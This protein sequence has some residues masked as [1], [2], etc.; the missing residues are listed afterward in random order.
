ME[1]NNIADAAVIV[2]ADNG[3]AIVAAD[4]RNADGN[5]NVVKNA[6]DAAAVDNFLAQNLPPANP[7]PLPQVQPPPQ[8]A[9]GQVQPPLAQLPPVQPSQVQPPPPQ[10]GV[11]GK[12]QGA[13]QQQQHHRAFAQGFGAVQQQPYGAFAQGY[14]AANHPVLGAGPF[15][16]PRAHQFLGAPAAGFPPPNAAQGFG[17][18]PAAHG[19][20]QGFGTGLAALGALDI[21]RLRDLAAVFQPQAPMV[22]PLAMRPGSSFTASEI[23]RTM[24]NNIPTCL[25]L[26]TT[27][28]AL[29]A[30]GQV[31]LVRRPAKDESFLAESM[32]ES[33][34]RWAR[35]EAEFRGNVNEPHFF[36]IL[37]GMQGMELAL[38]TPLTDAARD[39][40]VSSWR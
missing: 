3:N 6:E 13:I 11:G 40:L 18:G 10:A 31:A 35:L 34:S 20:P 14:G 25:P 28:Y 23:W 27:D 21:A 9:L 29:T 32:K 4:N 39:A 37:D 16:G 7:L 15:Q 2:A 8:Q 24:A 33:R 5:V 17:A 36:T 38:G 30:D 22:A 19:A 12:G 1:A 26:G